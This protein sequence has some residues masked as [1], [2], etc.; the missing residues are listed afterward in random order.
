MLNIIIPVYNAEKTIERTLSSLVA[1]TNKKFIVTI[2]NDCSTDSSLEIAETFKKK[3]LIS[4]HS[5]IR[6]LE[7]DWSWKN[8]A[9]W[10]S[11]EFSRHKF[12]KFISTQVH[13]HI[14]LSNIRYT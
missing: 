11:T 6:L 12:E 7:F 2:V 4:E 13:F 3:L 5:P 9:Y 1:Q 10:L 14:Q 8:I